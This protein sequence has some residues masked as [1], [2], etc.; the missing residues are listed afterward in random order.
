AVA[1]G[2]AEGRFG[3]MLSWEQ[4][5]KGSTE[6]HR[7]R[8]IEVMLK[9]TTE[10]C[11]FPAT[12]RAIIEPDAP[13]TQPG[14]KAEIDSA[15]ETCQ[16]ELVNRLDKSDVKDVYLYVHGVQNSFSDSVLTIAELWHF[17]G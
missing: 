1:F 15:M 10:L 8:D 5:V 6:K 4:L 3:E 13:A 11:R 16:Q 2:V 7:P 17:L 12:P 9:K 14:A